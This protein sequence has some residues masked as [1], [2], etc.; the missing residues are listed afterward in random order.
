MKGESSTVEIRGHCQRCQAPLFLNHTMDWYG[1]SVV[2]LNCWNGH[3]QWIN[4]QN[5]QEDLPAKTRQD[6]VAHIG[7]FTV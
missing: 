6:L 4:I 7:F 5:I 2:T 1:N 3:Y